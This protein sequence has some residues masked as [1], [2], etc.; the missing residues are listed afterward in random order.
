MSVISEK[1]EINKL[2]DKLSNLTIIIESKFNKKPIAACWRWVH[3]LTLVSKQD[4]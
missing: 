1:K 4:K 2:K 3:C